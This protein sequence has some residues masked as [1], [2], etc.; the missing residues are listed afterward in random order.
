LVVNALSQEARDVLDVVRGLD[1]G[2]DGMQP[3]IHRDQ[4][5]DVLGRPHGDAATQ[6]A[7]A[8]LEVIGDLENVTHREHVIGPIS[9][10]LV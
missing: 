4:V 8:E 3:E 5:N 7:L 2:S 1:L 6:R 10:T 9:F